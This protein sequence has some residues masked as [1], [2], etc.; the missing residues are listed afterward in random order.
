AH[1]EFA[2][3]LEA[4][5]RLEGLG[6]EALPLLH[7]A[8]QDSNQD[9]E[10]RRRLS[11]LVA[12]LEANAA[13]QPTRV[14]LDCQDLPI[15]EV[16]AE[17]ARQS[18]YKIELW[19]Q[20]NANAG[21]E[22]E[23]R[24]LTLQLKD[25]TFWEALHELCALGGLTFQEGWYG[26]DNR[27][28]RLDF[29]DAVPAFVHL[30]GPCRLVARGMNFYRSM[31]FTNL[32][33]GMNQ[34]WEKQ[35]HPLL[36]MSI[37][38][39]PRLPLLGVGQPV[40]ALAV[41]ENQ[42]SMRAPL[43]ND[44][45]T[46]RS[47]YYG[48]RGYM[49]HVQVPL[50]ATNGQRLAQLEGSL[51]VTLLALQR[52]KITVER[53]GNVK[54]ETFR[55]GTT[56]LTIEEVTQ[57]AGGQTQVRMLLAEASPRGNVDYQWINTVTQRLEVLD[58]KGNK[59]PSHGSNWSINGNAVSGTFTFGTAPNGGGPATKLIYYEWVTMTHQVPFSFRDLPLP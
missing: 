38:V 56:T 57:R 23:K 19:P 11:E 8:L 14:T 1:P 20:G 7:Q 21:D 34:P 35:D 15:R 22:R 48:N 50:K 29:G 5:T 46:Q 39:E 9:V 43:N 10:V 12:R 47:Y 42:Q 16:V 18:G 4:L 26:G 36:N 51:P 58:E 33:R 49:Q 40:V 41:D 6:A 54:S 52:P 17:L 44:P 27:A 30:E 53:L 45:R 2:V 13:L 59:L 55:A 3:R 25:V 32:T 31:D 24:V 28:I 37:T